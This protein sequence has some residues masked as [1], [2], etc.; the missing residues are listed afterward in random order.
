MNNG[1]S[2]LNAAINIIL[3]SYVEASHLKCKT[4]TELIK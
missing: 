1:N 4:N 3:H 2:L